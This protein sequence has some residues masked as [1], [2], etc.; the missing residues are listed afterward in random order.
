MVN[1]T[2]T[3][4]PPAALALAYAQRFLRPSFTLLLEIDN[5]LQGIL[6][7]AREPMIAHIKMAWW[8]EAFENVPS[9]R[10]KGEPL[11]QALND[12]GDVIPSAALESLVSAWE[13][14]LGSEHWA[15]DAVAAHA[16]LRSHAIF[17]TYA[18]WVGANQDVQAAGQV[19]ASDAL[20]QDFPDRFPKDMQRDSAPTLRGCKLRPLSILNMS[21]R[22]SSGQRLIWH[23]L[24]GL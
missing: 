6:E 2:S 4:A 7:H 3:L 12:V 21:V 8:R 10:P 18:H 9:A 22:T 13:I 20:R 14:L 5:R 19:W 1:G 17:Q 16:A 11:L 15:Q 23:A 24:T